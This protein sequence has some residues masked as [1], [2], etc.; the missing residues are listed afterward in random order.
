MDSNNA[1]GV[2]E[3]TEITIEK[4]DFA[5]VFSMGAKVRIAIVVEKK[6]SQMGLLDDFVLE[7]IAFVGFAGRLGW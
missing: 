1:N 2:K 6:D 4:S 3:A 5:D 7:E